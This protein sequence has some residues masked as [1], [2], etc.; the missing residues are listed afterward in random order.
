MFPWH[1][2]SVEV[3]HLATRP[4]RG[5]SHQMKYGRER[6]PQPFAVAIAEVQAAHGLLHRC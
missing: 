3:H 6:I 2:R 5:V 4:Q 1:A